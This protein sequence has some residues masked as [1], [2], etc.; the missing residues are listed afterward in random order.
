MDERIEDLLKTNC[1]YENE[2][3]TEQDLTKELTEK[4]KMLKQKLKMLEQNDTAETHTMEEIFARIGR[5][6]PEDF[7]KESK[8]RYDKLLEERKKSLFTD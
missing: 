5:S 8:K 4:Y 6:A 7:K 1:D 2:L 3:R